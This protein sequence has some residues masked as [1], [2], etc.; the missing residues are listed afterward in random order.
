VRSSSALIRAN[1]RTILSNGQ[2]ENLSKTLYIVDMNEYDIELFWDEEA[3]VWVASND[4]IPLALESGS[5]DTLIERVK[6]IAPE[7]LQDNNKPH[8][9][10]LN[11]ITHCREKAYA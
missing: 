4:D 3:R 8:D 1:P 11:F 6:H 9:V 10:Y 7:V 5:L 2:L